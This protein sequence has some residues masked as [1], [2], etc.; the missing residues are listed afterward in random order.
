MIVRNLY[1]TFSFHVSNLSTYSKQP[2][3]FYDGAKPLSKRVQGLNT[4]TKFLLQTTK[5][6]FSD[7]NDCF[8]VNRNFLH[9]F[10]CGSSLERFLQLETLLDVKDNATVCYSLFWV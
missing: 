5:L 4:I 8:T 10:Y 1:K 2:V 6:L 7:Q 9:L 3:T